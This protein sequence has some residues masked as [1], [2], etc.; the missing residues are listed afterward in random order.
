MPSL[1]A[2]AGSYRTGSFNRK[3]LKLAIAAARA[4]GAEVDEVDLRELGLPIYDG[5]LEE[6]SGLP[7]AAVDF[8]ERIR[9]ADALIIATPEYNHSMPAGLK[10]AIDWASRGKDQ[11]FRG[12]WAAIMSVSGGSSGGVHSMDHL[13]TS[14][15]TLGVW[16]VPSS[17]SVTFGGKA[18]TPEGALVDPKLQERVESVVAALLGRLRW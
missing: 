6:Q 13:R 8:R 15:T 5:D 18:F 7:A 16:L 2:I 9:R 1:V 14:L 4:A 12:K 3:L 17:A 10:N 11:P